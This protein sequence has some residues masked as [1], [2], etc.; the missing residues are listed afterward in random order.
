MLLPSRTRVVGAAE[1]RVLEI[2]IGSGLSLPLYGAG[3]SEVV[4]AD[5]SSALLSQASAAAGRCR[6]PVTLVEGSAEALA[7]EDRSVDTVV[8]TW[9]LRTIPGAGRGAERAAPWQPDVVRRT[10]TSARARHRPLARSARSDLDMQRRRLPSEPG[11]GSLKRKPV[12]FDVLAIE[13]RC[14]GCTSFSSKGRARPG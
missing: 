1:G 9:L 4:G 6:A 5:P 10:Q 3:V 11:H 7:S 14:Q 12:R 8:S 2:G 13:C